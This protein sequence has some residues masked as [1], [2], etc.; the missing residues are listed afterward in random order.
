VS[1]AETEASGAFGV[2]YWCPARTVGCPDC[3]LPDQWGG[4]L[5]DVCP[6]HLRIC[7]GRRHDVAA[8]DFNGTDICALNS[9]VKF[10]IDTAEEQRDSDLAVSYTTT[11]GVEMGDL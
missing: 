8:D 2:V 6:L 5:N 9:L 4:E 3:V 10:R 7:N 1:H 11:D